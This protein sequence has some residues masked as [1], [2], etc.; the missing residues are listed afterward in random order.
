MSDSL[1]PDQS[2]ANHWLEGAGELDVIDD[3]NCKLNYEQT[4]FCNCEKEFI[5]RIEKLAK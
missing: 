4:S 3:L 1:Q 5:K 2:H